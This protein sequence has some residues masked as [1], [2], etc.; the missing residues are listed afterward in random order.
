MKA[1]NEQFLA[2]SW[3]K[4]TA[5]DSK[6]STFIIIFIKLIKKSRFDKIIK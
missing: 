4:L 6:R 1:R 5:F 2:V 3:R